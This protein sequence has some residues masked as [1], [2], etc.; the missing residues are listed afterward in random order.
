MNSVSEMVRNGSHNGDRLFPLSKFKTFSIP[1]SWLVGGINAYLFSASGPF[2]RSGTEEV[3]HVHSR[4]TEEPRS[5]SDKNIHV[6]LV[7]I[8]RTC[9]R[10]AAALLF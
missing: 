9:E 1:L 2:D 10:Q 3:E 5:G 8:C 7:K 6:D 4:A